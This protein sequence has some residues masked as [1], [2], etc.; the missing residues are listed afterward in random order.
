MAVA[1]CRVRALRQLEGYFAMHAA[2]ATGGADYVK[3]RQQ[4]GMETTDQS[5]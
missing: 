2:E 5:P 3:I 4:Y 1:C